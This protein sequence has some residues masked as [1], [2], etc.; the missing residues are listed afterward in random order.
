MSRTRKILL[1]VA[2]FYVF[3][4]ILL[5]AIFGFTQHKNNAFQIQNEFKL[6]NWVSLGLF[7]INRAVLYLF[8]AALLTV[9]TMVYIADRMQARPNR[10]QTAVE[11]MF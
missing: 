7:S 4:L 10:V 2:G 3:G 8:L 5:V 11:V 9:L 1:A 6:I